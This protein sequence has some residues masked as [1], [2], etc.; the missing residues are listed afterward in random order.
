MLNIDQ[1]KLIGLLILGGIIG[2]IAATDQPSWREIVGM[3]SG[4]AIVVLLVYGYQ[5][6]IKKPSRESIDRR[7]E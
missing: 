6:W 3:L 2:L 4:G 7:R 1:K 5:P